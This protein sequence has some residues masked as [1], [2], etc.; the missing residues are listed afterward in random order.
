MFVVRCS[1]FVVHCSLLLQ[2]QMNNEQPSQRDALNRLCVQD[3]LATRR[4]AVRRAA[5]LLTPPSARPQVSRCKETFG[6]PCG[7]VRRPARDPRRRPRGDPPRAPPRATP[8]RGADQRDA[9]N[10]LCVQDGLATR[11]F[12]VRA[13]I[14]RVSLRLRCRLRRPAQVERQRRL[15]PRLD[16]RQREL[17]GR[18]AK[19]EEARGTP[20][21]GLVGV[22]RERCR[23]IGRRDGRRDRCSRRATGRI[24][25]STRSNTSGAWT[26][27]RRMQARRRLPGPVAHAGHELAVRRR[28]DAAARAGRCR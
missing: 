20:R 24:Q 27:N 26:R 8:R 3:R 5:G 9:L 1:L 13:R 12:A 22:D 2:K 6:R 16:R 4:F 18:V 10:R 7:G 17:A 23:T 14:G 21:F 25:V 11:R 28:S 19:R 15:G